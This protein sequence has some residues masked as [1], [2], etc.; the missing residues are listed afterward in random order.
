MASNPVAL[1][2]KSPLSNALSQMEKAANRI[3]LDEGIRRVLRTPKRVL[4]AHVPIQK[5]DG[6]IEVFTGYRV[7]HNTAR[8]PAKGGIRYHPEVTLDEVTAL[9]MWMT[10]KCAVLNVPF[11]GAKGGVVCDP[12][13][14]SRSELER[15]TRRFTAEI[16]PIIGPDKDIPAPDVYTD[17]QVMAWIMDTY[18]AQVGQEEPAVVT[19]KPVEIGGSLGRQEA[20]SRGCV[21]AVEE[22]ARSLG[23]SL[24]D[25]KV[26]VQGFGNVGFHAAR[27]LAE[28]GCRI[29]AVSDSSGGIYNPAGLD[30]QEL[31]R[32]KKEKRSVATY[33][34]GESISNEQLLELSCDVL[35]PAAL[36]GVIHRGNAARI[37]ARIVAEGA[38]GPTT[39][40]ADEILF[41]QGV[42]VVPDIL[43]NAGGVTVSYYEW[44]QGRQG[45]YWTEDEV[46]SRL[47]R[48]MVESFSN[49]W[50]EA[51]IHAV[52]LRTAA[53]LI[54]LRRVADAVRLRGI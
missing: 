28:N 4:T 50:H 7:Q 27:I 44:V 51:A 8:G 17:A 3:G 19:G 6:S 54:A 25:A 34:E 42:T 14:L 53:Y 48:A 31:L 11:G 1:T 13:T 20:T 52:D 35:V 32:H 37:K 23:L 45:I 40:E 46:N 24:G 49:V 16:S 39:P 5:D 18:S 22:A 43:A 41:E 2:P 36:D 47:R 9:S 12:K 38:N 30:P 29:I 15:I 21:V 33:P 10:W 26:C